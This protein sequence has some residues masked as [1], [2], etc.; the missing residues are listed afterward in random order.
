MPPFE[1]VI[2]D[3]PDSLQARYLLGQCYFFTER[4]VEAADTLEPLRQ[5]QSKDLNYLYVLTTSADKA[6]RKD[7]AESIPRPHGRRRRRFCDGAYA[8]R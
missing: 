1:P 2:K 4:Y 3:T 7:L 5:Q 8:D 6:E